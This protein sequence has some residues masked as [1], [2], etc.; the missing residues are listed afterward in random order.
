MEF[1]YESNKVKQL[2]LFEVDDWQGLYMNG[3]LLDQGHCIERDILDDA[4]LA[5]CT[6]P[7]KIWIDGDDPLEAVGWRFPETVEEL[8]SKVPIRI[9]LERLKK[10]ALDWIKQP[11]SNGM[12]ERY[13][14]FIDAPGIAVMTI[15]VFLHD[16]RWKNHCS[17]KSY[18]TA[19]EAKLVCEEHLAANLAPLAAIYEKLRGE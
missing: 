14:V 6:K 5:A 17:N 10:P 9:E 19:D 12:P 3:K 8:I 7:T 16:G 4:I 2:T 13:V 18:S 11:A 1:H 15:T